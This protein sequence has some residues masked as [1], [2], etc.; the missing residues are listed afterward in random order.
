MPRTYIL[1]DALDECSDRTEIMDMIQAMTKWNSLRLLVTSRRERDIE[2]SLA[3]YVI[4]ENKICLQSSL[5]DQDIQ[6][7]VRQRLSQDKRLIKWKKD[8]HIMSAIES[9][10]MNGANGM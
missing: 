6:L 4:E 2:D 7:Y 3:Q 8:A 9:A 5:V 1:L 10:L